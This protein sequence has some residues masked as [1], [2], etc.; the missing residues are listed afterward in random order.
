MNACS[1]SVAPLAVDRNVGD[2]LLIR[3][4]VDVMENLTI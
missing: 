4:G 1:A 3:L 2:K